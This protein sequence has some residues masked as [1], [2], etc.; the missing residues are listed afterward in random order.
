M[1]RYVTVHVVVE[2]LQNTGG[3]WCT[4][5]LLPS[6]WLQTVAVRCGDRMHL[7][8]RPWCDECGRRDTVALDQG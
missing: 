6:G 1:A 2:V 4:A 3:H 5:C 8:Q 7:Q